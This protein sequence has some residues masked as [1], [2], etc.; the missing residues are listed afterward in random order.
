M[1]RIVVPY[2]SLNPDTERVV[3]LSGLP[4]RFVYMGDDYSYLRLIEELW[5]EARDTLIIEHDIVPTLLQIWDVAECPADC[6]VILYNLRGSDTQ[7]L[8][9]CKISGSLMARVPLR[10]PE[11]WDHNLDKRPPMWWHVDGYVFANIYPYLNPP[12]TLHQHPGHVG[13]DRD[14]SLA[15]PH[16]HG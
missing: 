11:W 13:H 16:G 7:S 15:R 2:K 5:S 12:Y 8:G 14:M 1:T 10:Y 6:C 9:F 4:Y 3:R